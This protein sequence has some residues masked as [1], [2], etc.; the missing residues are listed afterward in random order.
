MRETENRQPRHRTQAPA[1]VGQ[2]RDETTRMEVAATEAG[3]EKRSWFDRWNRS[4]FV[5]KGERNWT[6]WSRRVGAPSEYN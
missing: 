3:R 6:P 5:M 4:Q 2:D 1:P